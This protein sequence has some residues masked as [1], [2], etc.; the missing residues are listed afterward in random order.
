M[1][2][3]TWTGRWLASRSCS[4]AIAAVA[5]ATRLE[6]GALPIS[7]GAEPSRLAFPFTYW[8]AAGVGFA[9][10]LV[11]ALHVS[12][13]GTR[14]WWVRVLAAAAVPGRGR[15]PLLHVL[16]RRPR[17]R[18]PWASSLYVAL[19]HSRR[20]ATTLLA[21]GIPTAIAVVVAYD[22]DVLATAEYAD[23]GSEAT[24]HD[25]RRARL[26][27]GRGRRCGRAALPLERRLLAVRVS[28][29]A[30]RDLLLGA[31]ARGARRRRR[32]SRS[33]RRW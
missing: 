5:L 15:R 26:R 3:A 8:N 16:A 28:R 10:G 25:A 23:A 2:A 33:P 19:A 27:A 21:I 22:A 30:R 14:A 6:P 7:A 13:G 24:R 1:R 31:S 12:A 29:P 17:A 11:L 9:L 18:R 20:L 32:S 4:A